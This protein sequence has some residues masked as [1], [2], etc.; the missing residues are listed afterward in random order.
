MSR[1]LLTASALTTLLSCMRKYYYRYEL[2]LKSTAE[3]AALS[4]GT[5]WHRVMEA[6]WQGKTA[7]E[8][9]SLALGDIETLDETQVATLTGLLTGY[10]K[11]YAEDPIKELHPE[12]EF[13]F[14]LAGSR[15]FDVA[16]KI[17]GLGTMTDGRPVLL[18]HK[19]T[20]DSVAPDSDYW[21]RLRAN[22]QIMQ[23]VH[24]ARLCGLPVEVVLYDVCRKP[25]IRPK[26][27]PVLDE[28]GRKIINDATGRRVLK[29]DGT[30]RE[31]AGDGMILQTREET[32]EE[33]GQR[34]TEDTLARPEFYFARREVPVLD[35]DLAEFEVQRLEISRMILSLRRA[36]RKTE[37]PHQA[38]PR[39]CS[40]MTCSFCD[41]KDF[42]LQNIS[43]D[44]ANPPAG[45]TVGE[46][47]PELT[48][49]EGGQ[50]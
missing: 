24:A 40:E 3:R 16:G 42:C 49:G 9:L 43:V 13:Q 44:Q 2:G 11:A 22:G 15:S 41:Y 45:F 23:Y 30:P 31:S 37:K 36:S 17:D 12:Q 7:E 20:S 46:R 18:E 29:K 6:R 25:S 32:P 33:Y 8:A 10:Y 47:N 50:K 35:Q 34:L 1:E 39:N 19:T 38:Y 14:A 21:L 27:I 28:Q 4:F 26:L 48:N 5:A